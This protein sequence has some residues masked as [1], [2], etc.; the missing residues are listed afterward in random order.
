M[1]IK[2]NIE[3]LEKLETSKD[4]SFRK[5]M[6]ADIDMMA[7]EKLDFSDTFS[8]DEADKEKEE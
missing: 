5:L 1:N 8:E 3:E 6:E 7:E 4:E 2:D